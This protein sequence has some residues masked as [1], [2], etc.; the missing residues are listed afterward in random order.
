M[1][2]DPDIRRV[3]AVLTALAL[4]LTTSALAEARRVTPGESFYGYV[5]QDYFNAFDSGI[6]GT[7]VEPVYGELIADDPELVFKT[8]VMDQA[9]EMIGEQTAAA[10]EA[11]FH[12]E[13]VDEPDTPAQRVHDLYDSMRHA[14]EDHAA[15]D[16]R[17]MAWADMLAQAADPAAFLEAVKTVYRETGVNV[18]YSITTAQEKETNAT[19]PKVR[20]AAPTDGLKVALDP[21]M[22]GVYG[23]DYRAGQAAL[24]QCLGVDATEA[25]VDMAWA[26]QRAA[27][28]ARPLVDELEDTRHSRAKDA[29][30]PYTEEDYQADCD[31]LNALYPD[32]DTEPPEGLNAVDAQIYSFLVYTGLM[33]NVARPREA[34]NADLIG[35]L[36]DAGFA[37][38]QVIVAPD[39]L[40]T[41]TEVTGDNLVAL[42]LNA[43]M[44]LSEGLSYVPDALSEPMARMKRAAACAMWGGNDAPADEADTSDD[45]LK[46]ETL[47]L[48][49]QD[50]GL[51]WAEKYYDDTLTARVEAITERIFDAYIRRVERNDWLAQSEKDTIIRKLNEMVRLIGVPDDTQCVFPQIVPRAQGGSLLVNTAALKRAELQKDLNF[52]NI[53][54][55]D[56]RSF[57]QCFFYSDAMVNA[58]MDNAANNI[59]YNAI[60]IP[61]G[62]IAEMAD[63]QD[64]AHLLATIGYVIAHEIGH[65]F[66]ATGSL[67]NEVGAFENWWSEASRETFREIEARFDAHYRRFPIAEGRYQDFNG[68]MQD[69]MA[70]FA[71]MT[72]ILDVVDGDPDAQRIILERSTAMNATVGSAA[73]IA[74]NIGEFTD[75]HAYPP[76]R[77]N[78]IVSAM[79]CFYAL[80]DVKPGDPMYTAPE[81]RPR[82]W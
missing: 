2:H 66:D 63:P 5:N 67:H 29:D 64:D 75:S 20:M 32:T 82:L 65:A 62:F 51:L 78:A 49:F 68:N 3:M 37:C 13:G 6:E 46:A 24:A 60:V 61:A 56:R 48:L 42:K 16:A 57:E 10:A 27:N 11:A 21:E 72:A 33:D 26:L 74:E 22:S 54:G 25:D 1:R 9:D 43:V 12:G 14:A 52:V 15:D 35:V 58:A 55:Y 59:S 73:V 40:D 39:A 79:D 81:E 36:E 80:Y 23:P 4:A 47:K 34:L 69:N 19:L 28:P 38:E 45:A 53:P 17:F 50:Q 76:V 77:T 71:G 41:L 18:L 31:R 30:D 70:D 8:G 7:W 44:V